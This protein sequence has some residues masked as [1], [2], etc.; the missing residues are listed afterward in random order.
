MKSILR[1]YSET[2]PE[3]FNLD[4]IYQKNNE[5]ILGYL[6]DICEALNILNGIEY[7]GSEIITNEREAKLREDKNM[8]VSRMNLIILKF[9]ITGYSNKKKEELN[10]VITIPILF[11]KII[12]NFYFIHN[13]NYY[14][15][16]WQISDKDTYVVGKNE[17]R[18]LVLK[19]LLLPI[20]LKFQ[21]KEF[22]NIE[23]NLFING[24]V[25]YLHLF[26]KKV[27]YLYYYFNKFGV[28][29][30]IEYFGYE[31]Q[32]IISKELD[33]NLKKKSWI[34]FKSPTNFYIYAKTTED[35]DLNYK[36]FVCSLIDIFLESK[37][38]YKNLESEKI[39]KK[40]LGSFFTK[41]LNNQVEKVK[42]ILISF[43]RILDNRTKKVL[44]IEEEDKED[45]Y[46]LVKWMIQN[47]Y[48]LS[49][50]DN[51]DLK[52]KRLRLYEYMI[53][54]LLMKFSKATYRMLNNKNEK[55]N[56]FEQLKSIFNIK[57]NTITKTSK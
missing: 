3:K 46:A 15:P 6:N 45:I 47:Y 16:I 14:F 17:R 50:K 36:N 18:Q 5:S 52:N 56:T 1:S 29:G 48:D 10:E 20:V 40:K 23:D 49:L 43:E 12:N 33:E 7:L 37:I 30:T 41:N 25:F 39:W 8:N 27:N 22:S 55:K 32:I 53:N 9:K 2:N 51:M 21:F 57:I 4:F 35:D 38:R 34:C 24:R 44:K 31:D 11:P 28:D 42:S 26:S 19:T 54:P 13:G